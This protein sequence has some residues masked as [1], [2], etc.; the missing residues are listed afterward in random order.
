M[1]GLPLSHRLRLS[2]TCPDGA[3]SPQPTT[4][5]NLIIIL[6]FI[7]GIASAW[8]LPPSFQMPF[9]LSGRPKSPPPKT[10][11]RFSIQ[12]D[13]PWIQENSGWLEKPFDT[14][15]ALCA[16]D[17]ALPKPLQRGLKSLPPADL[18]RHLNIT[19][20]FEYAHVNWKRV[21]H[22]LSAIENCP[23]AM[24]N[25]ESLSVQIPVDDVGPRSLVELMDASRA[26]R[27]SV[28]DSSAKRGYEPPPELTAAF[29]RVLQ[30][31]SNLSKLDWHMPAPGR[32]SS[33]A[34]L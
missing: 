19:N 18:F 15:T 3:S 26:K 13:H 30:L 31:M 12:V 16:L 29:V 23:A 21:H 4:D 27:I 2:A 10:T 9:S 7:L 25:I 28:L 8:Q 14:T 24:Q 5:R 20:P 11:P 1:I 17:S 6:T 32:S 33:N 34:T 22:S